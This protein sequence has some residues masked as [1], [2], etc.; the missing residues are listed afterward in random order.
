MPIYEYHC[1]DC[2]YDEEVIQKMSDAPLTQCPHCG[3]HTFEKQVSASA[4]HL[5]GEGW[6]VT[7]FRDKKTSEKDAKTETKTEKGTPETAKDS[8]KE[9]KPTQTDAKPATEKSPA[10]Q[11]KPV[12]K[13]SASTTSKTNNKSEK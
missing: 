10:S 8:S 3:K 4:F 6:Y 2:G 9:N 5:K 7:D 11:D 1:Q 13:A 12:K